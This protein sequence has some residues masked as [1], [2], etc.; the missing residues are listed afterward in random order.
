VPDEPS[1]TDHAGLAAWGAVIGGLLLGWRVWQWRAPTGEEINAAGSGALVLVAFAA[2]W[3]MAAFTFGACAVY[4]V[5]KALGAPARLFGSG[6]KEGWQRSGEKWDR[7]EGRWP[8]P[9]NR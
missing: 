7:G 3:T 2:F 1:K 6:L 4:G 8:G 9:W 5:L